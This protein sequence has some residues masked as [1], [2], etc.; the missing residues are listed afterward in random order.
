MSTESVDHVDQDYGL[1]VQQPGKP[2]QVLVK[3][4][5]M[6]LSYRYG[7]DI[8]VASSFVE[9]FALIKKHGSR[10]RCTFIIHSKKLDSTTVVSGL[11]QDGEIPLFL[12]LP[13]AL[14]EMH[15]RMCHRIDNVFFCAWE[16]AFRHTGSSLHQM[17]ETAF[18]EHGIGE[19][20]ENLENASHQEAQQRVA[21]R[22]QNLNTL[23]TLPEVALR[24]LAMVDDPQVTVEDLEDVLINDPAIVHKLLRVVNSPV[25]AGSGHQG[26]WTLQEA[27]VRL[28]RRKVGAIAHQIKLMNSLVR[29]EDS[30]FDLHRFWEHSVGCALIADR[31][32]TQKLVPLPQAI[33]FNDYWIGGLLHDI[34]KLVMG[35]FFWH[36]FELVLSRMASEDIS[37]REAEKGF[38]DAA[39]HEYLGRLLLLTSSVGEDLVEAVGTHHTT[40]K[41]PASLVCLIHLANN[42]SKDLGLGYLREERT[43]YSESVLKV[44]DLSE[45]DVA[46]LKEALGPAVVREI[47][48]IVDRCIQAR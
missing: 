14:I 6:I 42:I 11:N 46:E 8:I 1:I 28:G 24:I 48:E 2:Q 39:N 40:G 19:L 5:M 41:S 43:E 21:R 22:L 9:A 31:L 38:G 44:L 15:R 23:P 37:F 35:F 27:I 26:G 33:A 36:H 12:L 4:L 20:F 45:E 16:R 30:L 3:S 17:I 32:Y 13:V 25:F 7:L 47:G 29:P 10:V 34:G 18:A